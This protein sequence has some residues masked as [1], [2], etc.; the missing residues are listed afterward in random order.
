LAL[1]FSAFVLA[2]C[3][4]ANS[5]L[6]DAA[7][8]GGAPASSSGGAGGTA[9]GAG[10][11]NPGLEASGGA[12][13]AAVDATTMVTEAGDVPSEAPLVRPGKALIYIFSNLYFRHPS[14]ETAAN[15][16]Q[17]ALQD[18]GFTVEISKDQTKFSTAGLADLTLVIMI[19]SCGTPLGAPETQSVAALDA[20]LKAGGAFVGIHAASAVAYPTTSRFVAIMGGRFV[21]HPGDVRLDACVAQG[22]HPSVVNLPMPFNVRDEIYVHDGFNP[23]NQVDLQCPGLNGGMLPIAWHR[24]EGMGRVFYSA[25]GHDIGEWVADGPLVK[26]HVLP[27]ILWATGQ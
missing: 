8:T 3:S 1:V 10:G 19:G 16:L 24:T 26:N 7:N 12:A 6:S 15:T 17:L 22:N 20:W 23:A 4:T 9:T 18:R 21:N 11:Q 2:S 5:G 27:G 14:I 25:L 13:G